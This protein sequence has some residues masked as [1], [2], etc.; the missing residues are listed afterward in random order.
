MYPSDIL[1]STLSAVFGFTAKERAMYQHVQTPR[2]LTRSPDGMIAGV[3]AGVSDYCG[4]NL[5]FTRV[6]FILLGLVDGIGL[7]LYIILLIVIPASPPA[8]APTSTDLPR[9]SPKTLF[10][11]IAAAVSAC[12]AFFSFVGD[13]G[14]IIQSILELTGV[15][16]P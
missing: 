16:L 14:F 2:H 7:I 15:L 8:E 12:A 9:K 1:Y 4:I 10:A 5:I 13:V 3:C 6:V 11:Y